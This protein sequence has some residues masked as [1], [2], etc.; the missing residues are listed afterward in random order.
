MKLI[1]TGIPINSND[2][3]I[4]EK[5]IGCKLPTEY[6]EFMLEH[7]GGQTEIDMVFDF[8]D[9]VNEMDNTSVIREFFKIDDG[10]YNLLKIYENL[11]NSDAM[12]TAMIAIADDPG[13]NIISISLD[14]DDYGTVYYLDHE[15]AEV[16]SDYLMRS[17]ISNDFSEFIEKLFPDEE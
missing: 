17:K 1:K 3:D 14:S 9:E 15:Y 4:V 12:R 10:D 13:G 6:C 16:D 8:Y 2:L 7:N 11:V 5:T